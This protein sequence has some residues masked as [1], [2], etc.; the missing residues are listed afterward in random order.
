MFSG[1]ICAFESTGP[2]REPV[3]G[4]KKLPLSDD[5]NPPQRLELAERGLPSPD[6][7]SES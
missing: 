5:G 7:A 6:S 3:F 4:G 2:E 1:A